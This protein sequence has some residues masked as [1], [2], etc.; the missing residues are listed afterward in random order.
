MSGRLGLLLE[1]RL[2]RT[3]VV[4]E[5]AWNRAAPPV[6][7]FQPQNEALREVKADTSSAD[8]LPIPPNNPA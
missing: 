6:R 8:T 7:P 4:E 5:L 2:L 3:K 1:E